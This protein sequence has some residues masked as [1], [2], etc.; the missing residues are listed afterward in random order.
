MITSLVHQFGWLQIRYSDKAIGGKVA[1]MQ[2]VERQ[3]FGDAVFRAA[4]I[5][6]HPDSKCSAD[7]ESSAEM[8][9]QRLQP[10]F[11][12]WHKL[13]QEDSFEAR[14]GVHH[15]VIS[16]GESWRKLAAPSS[17]ALEDLADAV[18]QVFQF[19]NEN[20]YR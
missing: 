10:F 11:P 13:I 19:E 3:A 16:I 18:L 5:A 20:L 4:R 17:V 8:L 9:Q 2:S 1:L 6:D 7:G 15:F 12:H 14:E